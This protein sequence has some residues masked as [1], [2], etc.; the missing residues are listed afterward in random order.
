MAGFPRPKGPLDIV[1]WVLTGLLLVFVIYV[2]LDLRL[3]DLR[4]WESKKDVYFLEEKPLFTTYDGFLFARYAKEYQ[5][6]L[7]RWREIDPLRFVPDNFLQGEIR[8]RFPPLLSVLFAK[9]SALTGKPVENLS[10]YFIPLLAVFFTIPLVLYLREAGNFWA[11]ALLGAF[12]GVTS[13]IYLLRTSVARLDTDCLNLFFPF[14]VLFFLTRYLRTLRTRWLVAAS[15]GLVLFGWWYKAASP[16]VI[17]ILLIFSVLAWLQGGRRGRALWR[18]LALLFLP[19]LWYLWRAPVQFYSY[20]SRLLFGAGTTE[21]L[22]SAYP[23]VLRSISE[24][25]ASPDLQKAAFFI[26]D[27]KYL[28]L[29]GLLGF[30]LFLLW[31]RRAVLLSL[32]LFLTGLLLFKAGN[33]FGMYLAPF[34][35]MGLGFLVQGSVEGPERFFPRFLSP[36]S[37]RALI[38]LLTLIVGLGV[39]FN[40]KPSWRYVAVPK[41]TAPIARQIAA[42]QRLTPQEAW[43]W[44]WW[45]YGYAISDLGR[46]AVFIDGGTQT[47]PKT[48]YIALSFTLPSPEEGRNVTAFVAKYGLAGIE[49]ELKKGLSP[50]ELTK[51]MREGTLLKE[52]PDHPVY[53]LFTGDLLR[54]YGWIGYFGSWDFETRQGTYGVLMSSKSCRVSGNRFR[55][56]PFDLDV[57]TG[58]VLWGSRKLRLKKL[59][60]KD[61]RG[62]REKVFPTQ[63]AIGELIAT[64]HGLIFVLVDERTFASNFNQMFL[65][66]KY[67][68]TLFELVLDDFP[69]AVLYRVKWPSSS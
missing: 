32:P 16:L 52:W 3:N 24:L 61:A 10:L 47:T 55:C 7:Y 68:P 57:A 21:R 33:R 5:E 43:I 58:T 64:S 18:D 38:L 35:G 41:I 26:L 31:E 66:R 50:A 67:D 62:L 4:V 54:K 44:S 42:L 39:W 12:T 69:F 23:N 34:V 40:Q 15:V 6:G 13:L 48:Y 63:G 36:L 51:A 60:T 27:H 11:P 59:V 2:G 25:N 8:Y 20:V 49:E 9:L 65:L 17:G 53:W 37:T 46:R 56:P 1:L 22:F 14:L 30:V 45:D 28:F 19:Q 29:A